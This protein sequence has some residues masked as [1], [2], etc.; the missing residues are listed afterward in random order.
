MHPRP[1]SMASFE[2]PETVALRA[3][4]ERY[5]FFVESIPQLVWSCDPDGFTTDFSQRCLDYMGLTLDEARNSGWLSSVHPDD[6]QFAQQRWETAIK[7]G[8]DYVGEY[9][10]RR[11]LDGKYRWFKATARPMRDPAGKIMAWFGT[12]TDID[13]EKRVQEA[14]AIN[15]E[16]LRFY[17]ETTR[18]G[19]WD[20]D[21]ATDKRNWSDR[22]FELLGLP[23]GD[24]EPSIEVFNEQCHPDDRAR[25]E[26]GLKEVLSQGD[27]GRFQCRVKSL[28]GEYHWIQIDCKVF[29]D[30]EGKPVR[31]VGA[32]TDIHEQKVAEEKI[33]AL[34]ETLEERVRERTR[35]LEATTGELQDFCHSVSH[36]LRG[37]LRSINGFSQALEEDYA[38][39]LDDEGRDH[40]ARIRN[41]TIKLADLIDGLLSMSRIT[42]ADM[43]RRKVD[44]SAIAESIIDDL[45]ASDPGRNVKAVIAPNLETYGDVSLIQ[46]ALTNLIENAWKF[47]SKTE[48][49]VIE[50]DSQGKGTFFVKDNGAGFDMAYVDKIFAPFQ[51]L[52]SR[53]EYPGDGIG[54]AIVSRVIQRHGGTV[55]AEGTVNE[56]ARIKFTLPSRGDDQADDERD[57]EA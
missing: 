13:T 20:W 29:R 47:T 14:L 12:S 4:E 38:E 25:I 27:F 10:V 9:R 41:A 55:S 52:H 36:D 26:S 32:N 24:V 19:V 1:R 50:L 40:L 34:N 7:S 8:A 49:A 30:S 22:N 45:R 17:L 31:M 44:V 56:G 2:S 33:K 3:S 46:V 23:L 48:N 43:A 57:R 18:D 5:R 51:R 28:G 15:E 35:E 37:P 16:R 21:I 6:I 42:R 54:L 53:D 11:A 39:K